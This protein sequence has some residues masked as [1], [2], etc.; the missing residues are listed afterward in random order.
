MVLGSGT[1]G[2]V[3]KMNFKRKDVAVKQIA[4]SDDKDEMKV[5]KSTCYICSLSIQIALASANGFGRYD[6]IKLQFYCQIFRLVHFYYERNFD[7]SF[8]PKINQAY[9]LD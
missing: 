4:K 2:T 8:T 3:F 5:S 6:E 9:I 7:I 1:S